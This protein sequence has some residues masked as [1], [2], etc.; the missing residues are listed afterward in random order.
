MKDNSNFKYLR[1]I[2]SGMLCCMTFC[3]LFSCSPHRSTD[4]L[5]LQDIFEQSNEA[6]RNGKAKEAMAGFKQCISQ[7]SLPNMSKT[8]A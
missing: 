6:H 4:F 1:S 7:C 5:Q 3:L 2:V 8:T